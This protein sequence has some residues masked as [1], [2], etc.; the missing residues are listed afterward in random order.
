[1]YRLFARMKVMS[2][3]LSV[4]L[5]HHC[6]CADEWYGRDS[7]AAVI[8]ST[9]TPDR[10]RVMSL[11]AWRMRNTTPD[12]AR[13]LA[14]A[15]VELAQQYQLPEAEA[16]SYNVL[17]HYH[18]YRN[19]IDSAYYY[20]RREI[21]IADKHGLPA[22]KVYA[23][24]NLGNIHLR[25]SEYD[26]A[27][28]FYQQT[29][30]LN[31]KS[32]SLQSLATSQTNIGL[33]YYMKGEYPNALDYY[34]DAYRIHNDSL[35]SKAGFSALL[36]NMGDVFLALHDYEQA[37]NYYGHS[38]RISEQAADWRRLC[39]SLRQSGKVLGLMGDTALAEERFEAA[40]KYA[41]ELKDPVAIIACI[42]ERAIL[43]L[44]TGRP[45]EARK[46]L[47]SYQS[48]IEGLQS[49]ALKAEVLYIFG[50]ALFTEKAYASALAVLMEALEIAREKESL[51][52][53][54][55]VN[56]TLF[57]L[58]TELGKHEKANLHA[59]DFI[60]L[61]DQLKDKGIIKVLGAYQKYEQEKG[62]KELA[63]MNLA[64]A[65]QERA[66]ADK[67]KTLV[68][69]IAILLGIVLVAFML[70]FYRLFRE[71]AAHQLHMLKDQLHQ[72]K[73]AAMARDQELKAIEARLDGEEN[74]RER[75]A[76]ELHDGIGGTLGGVK[77]QLSAFQLTPDHTAQIVTMIDEVYEEVRMISRN[78]VSPAIRDH[79]LTDL[80]RK[81]LED[82][83]PGREMELEIHCFP[84]EQLNNLE[85]GLKTDLYRIIQ[86]LATNIHKHANATEVSVQLTIHTGYINLLVEDNGQ[87]FQ[88]S[89]EIEG[90]GLV[91]ITSRV[92][93]LQGNFEINSHPGKGTVANIDIPYSKTHNNEQ[94]N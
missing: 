58:C 18:S 94:T 54:V 50:R 33:V 86:E 69:V 46:S 52:L 10:A 80:I 63:R 66:S 14:I 44:E 26:S 25:R 62:D 1:M 17:G 51:S 49:D 91:N 23:Y 77:L 11:L 85:D 4:V 79:K 2:L 39:T 83:M 40:E 37:L 22:Y 34:Y 82:L 93:L 53:Q 45:G 41:Q 48:M 75:L 81:Y 60:D 19:V 6:A 67:Q 32:G 70:Y 35:N 59:L 31:S 9:P 8:Q 68:L 28:Y 89:D 3:V 71:R 36:N 87:G 65:S 16:L 55:A 57:L 64:I 92:R 76:R 24:Q 84:E 56:K 61:S 5:G 15:A 29:K 13:E 21:I 12:R 27:L 30:I 90:I 74:E 72:Q 7:I 78:L 43:L 42:K 88:V 73:I 38:S 20:F 47:K